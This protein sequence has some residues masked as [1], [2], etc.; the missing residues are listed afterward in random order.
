M[1]LSIQGGKMA[2]A[3]ELPARFSNAGDAGQDQASRSL[4]ISDRLLCITLRGD[5]DNEK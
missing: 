5:D 2:L 3:A 4:A 1:V